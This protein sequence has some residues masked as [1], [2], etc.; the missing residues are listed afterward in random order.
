MGRQSRHYENHRT[1]IPPVDKPVEPKIQH[2]R[3]W[4]KDTVMTI[5]YP[6]EDQPNSENEF[7]DYPIEIKDYHYI[8]WE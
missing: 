2:Y 5:D 4:Y 1:N 7:E 6:P 8:Y 3:L